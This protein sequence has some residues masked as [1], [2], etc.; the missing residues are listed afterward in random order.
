MQTY[1]PVS[2]TLTRKRKQRHYSL[3]AFT[4][5]FLLLLTNLYL[6]KA[7]FEGYMLMLQRIINLVSQL[8]I[9]IIIIIIAF[10]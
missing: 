7:M 10:H 1:N 5:D 3:Q 2:A 6:F 4:V 8:L 9:L